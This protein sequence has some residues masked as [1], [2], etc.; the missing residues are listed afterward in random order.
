MAPAYYGNKDYINAIGC[1]KRALAIGYN[2]N[3]WQYRVEGRSLLGK[4]Y[5]QLYKNSLQK[6]PENNMMFSKDRK[7]L[8][9]FAIENLKAA[10]DSSKK[11][12]DYSVAG[13]ANLHLSEA[14][15]L[16][17]NTIEALNAYKRYSTYKDSAL[18]ND[19]KDSIRRLQLNYEFVNKQDSIK[20]DA[21]QKKLILEKDLQLKALRFE[22]E[23]RQNAVKSEKERQLLLLQE[24]VKRQQIETNFA[25]KQAELVSKQQRK[26][27]VME[28]EKNKNKEALKL[29]L[30][31]Q[32]VNKLQ[33]RQQL[34]IG[35]SA[36]I[37]LLLIVSSY[38][39]ISRNN[40]KQL[41]SQILQQATEQKLQEA[42]YKNKLNDVS[43]A[44][45]R[46]QMNPHFVFN[47]LNSINLYIQQNDTQYA[48]FYLNK[49]AS[50]IRVTLD[51]ARTEKNDLATELSTIKMYLEMEAMRFKDKLKYAIEIDKNVDTEF[52]EIPPLLLQPYIENAIWHG[53]MPK[54]NGGKIDIHFSQLQNPD[55][56]KI[57]IADDGIGRKKSEALKKERK[58]Q[59]I[60]HST[61][62]NKER[63]DII[64]DKHND[65]ASIITTDLMDDTNTPIGTL[66][67]IKLPLI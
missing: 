5:L 36:F 31:E 44:A 41:Q 43:F 45:L 51:S 14:Y 49:F 67:T 50:F 56:L 58:Y 39:F 3:I 20:F 21:E 29:S 9:D 48:S 54:E 28:I 6:L 47:C 25:N 57:T 66:V 33:F 24:S 37:L 60:S 17:G 13:E 4:S 38:F 16:S 22:Y 12:V 34:I 35:A 64:N 1:V 19:Q 61:Q 8:L 30:E 59:Y 7:K 65:I 52:I 32:K 15:E 40:N 27:L 18:N 53:L 26:N 42:L 62:I 10:L 63:I 11:S 46:S 23:K 55:L 2:N